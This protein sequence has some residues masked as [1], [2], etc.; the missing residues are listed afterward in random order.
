MTINQNLTKTQNALLKVTRGAFWVTR[1]G[2]DEDLLAEGGTEVRL[3]GRGWI[4]QKL[5][6]PGLEEAQGELLALEP[7]VCGTVTE[8]NR[9]TNPFLRYKRAAY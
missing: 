4:I 3:E 9:R 1:T 5:E 2:M 8:T 7:P 6:Q